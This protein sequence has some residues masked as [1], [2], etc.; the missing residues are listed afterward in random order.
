MGIRMSDKQVNYLSQ[1]NYLSFRYFH[2]WTHIW[3]Y[4]SVLGCVTSYE[5]IICVIVLFL[6]I[7][8]I[9]HLVWRDVHCFDFVHSKSKINNPYL[10]PMCKNYET[11]MLHYALNPL[12]IQIQPKQHITFFPIGSWMKSIENAIQ[13]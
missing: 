13:N 2:L 9:L 10:F 7:D 8:K 3:V 4:L 12:Q 1:A 5:F 11:K 6:F